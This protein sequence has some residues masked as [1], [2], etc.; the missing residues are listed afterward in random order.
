[1]A[2]PA[3]SAGQTLKIYCSGTNWSG[4][5]GNR[6]A[7]LFSVDGTEAYGGSQ[8][9]AVDVGYNITNAYTTPD[10]AL[11]VRSYSDLVAQSPTN[12]GTYLD[13]CFGPYGG[14]QGAISGNETVALQFDSGHGLSR[15]ESVY[16]SGQVSIYGFTSDPGFTDLA[17]GSSGAQYSD[18][19]LS[20][21]PNSGHFSYFF[22]NRAAS[23]GQTL[24]I[25]ADPNA[26]Y[27]FAIA[28]IGYA[29]MHTLFGTDIP[30]G[31]S[32]YTNSDGLL[33]I[34]AYSDTPGV[35]P[36]TFNETVYNALDWLG[37]TGGNSSQAIDGTESMTLQFAS[38]VGLSGL[39]VRYTGG[40]IILD[41]LASDPGLVGPGGIPI[42]GTYANGTL[43]FTANNAWH[44]SE[45]VV[46]FTNPAAS[47]G[48]TLSLHT[49]GSSG[50]QITLTKINY[51]NYVAAVTLSISYI[52]NNQVVLTWPNGTLQ[53]A[54]I[55]TGTYT[56]LTGATSP[57]TNA[58]S[59]HQSYFRV[60]VQ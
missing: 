57:Y 59:G 30:S 55:V 11:S 37:I 47:A 33:T 22:T 13:Q 6:G 53:Q 28:G 16:S 7:A 51:T 10:G 34:S 39:G 35:T 50:A 25:N 54:P 48:Q 2:N 21:Y 60:K 1:L 18:G 17:N 44:P 15:L 52:G 29:D 42:G 45:S 27:Y 20:F 36:A 32:S 14:H 3:A 26:G 23:A 46:Y 9:H 31:S 43:T 8:V 5:C 19:L 12:F 56:N 58:I 41:G 49:D 40:T 38:S 24:R 4:T